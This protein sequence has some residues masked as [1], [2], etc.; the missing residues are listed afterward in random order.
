MEINSIINGNK[1]YGDKNYFFEKYFL[2]KKFR[3]NMLSNYEK[4]DEVFQNIQ[5][6][7]KINDLKGFKL[8]DIITTKLYEILSS[9]KEHFAHLLSIETSVSIEASKKKIDSFL[10]YIKN[11]NQYFIDFEKKLKEENLFLKKKGGILISISGT[12]PLEGFVNSFIPAIYCGNTVYIKPSRK[13]PILLNEIIVKLSRELP[14]YSFLFNLIFVDNELI[15]ELITKKY[16][17]FIYW[18]GSFE[19]SMN[20]KKLCSQNTTDFYFE[21]SGHDFMFV[22]ELVCEKKISQ[23]IKDSFI[24]LNG[25]SC[26]KIHAIFCYE[27]D[28]EK[29]ISLGKD[30]I[31]EIGYLNSIWELENNVGPSFPEKDNIQKLIDSSEGIIRMLD[32]EGD[33]Y[34][35]TLIKNPDKE[36]IRQIGPINSPVISLMKVDSFREIIDFLNKSEYGLAFSIFSQDNKKIINLINQIHV[37]RINVNEN[38]LNVELQEPWGGLK[39]SGSSGAMNWIEKFSYKIYIKNG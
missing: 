10:H 2:N 32:L 31:N 30:V 39:N 9:E 14:E 34:P 16:F 3:V 4:F 20:I 13:S 38:P 35:P 1:I 27:R 8:A 25:K 12:D 18:S 6:K 15:Q 24:E 36:K 11:F 33:Y 22:E 19:S 28:Y 26:N 37:S 21:G 7:V 23:S 29:M 5:N 17:D